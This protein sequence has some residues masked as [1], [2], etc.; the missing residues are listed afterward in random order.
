VG[1]ERSC[2]TRFEVAGPRQCQWETRIKRKRKRARGHEVIKSDGP[3]YKEKKRAMSARA[4]DE[5]SEEGEW[6][7]RVTKHVNR[8]SLKQGQWTDDASMMLCLADSL[9]VCQGF[10]GKDL[11]YG[12]G[13]G[14][15]EKRRNERNRN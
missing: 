1:G 13:T 12:E 11:R 3:K 6:G 9:L 15:D 10:D 14:R 7:G 4:R 5:E 8:F 2:L